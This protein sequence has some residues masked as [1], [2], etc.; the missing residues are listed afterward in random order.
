METIKQRGINI[1]IIGTPDIVRVNKILDE[2]EII[3]IKS[4][5]NLDHKPFDKEPFILK[6]LSSNN[7][8]YVDDLPRVKGH[9]RPYKYHR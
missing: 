4:E 3:D 8:S 5:V 1:V 9:V 2:L 6:T 7:Y